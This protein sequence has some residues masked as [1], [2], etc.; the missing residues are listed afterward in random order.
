LS[1]AG[2]TPP[3]A[4]RPFRELLGDLAARTPAPGGGSAAAWATA[5]AAGLVE[6]AAEFAGDTAKAE[7]A[8]AL[9]A[10]ALE[11][12]ELELAA[13][14]PV[15]DAIRLPK[16][17]PARA[18]QLATALSEAADTPL[19]I[20]RAAAEAARLGAELA[21]GGNRSLEG[22]ANAGAQLGRGACRA[23]ARLVEINLSARPDDPRA[24]EARRLV[25][26]VGG[27]RSEVRGLGS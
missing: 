13:Y 26:E 3:H 5:L 10:R 12:A 19:E 21:A 16:E 2:A 8:A 7:R 11:L 25:A 22:D 20:A 15:L 27:Q 14:Q 17:D 18:E 6:M 1:D 23:A 4:E 9:R 24:A